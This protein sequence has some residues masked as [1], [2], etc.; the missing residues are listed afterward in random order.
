MTFFVQ[1]HNTHD[2]DAF[3]EWLNQPHMEVGVVT[4]T[5][6]GNNVPDYLILSAEGFSAE[7]LEQHLSNSQRDRDFVKI[8]SKDA[9]LFGQA[10]GFPLS[11][12]VEPLRHKPRLQLVTDTPRP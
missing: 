10:T 7:Y 6:T 12:N 2:T 3:Q 5:P 9:N 1:L 11:E 4:V 8:Y